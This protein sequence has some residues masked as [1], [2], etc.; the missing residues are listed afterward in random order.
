MARPKSTTVDAY[1]AHQPRGSRAVLQRVRGII[2]RVLPGAEETISYQIP[3][4]KVGGRGVVAFAGWKQHWSIYPV[5]DAI[6]ASPGPEANSYEFSKGTMRFPLT[7]RV[8]TTLVERVVRAVARR[9]EARQKTRAR[10][11][12]RPDGRRRRARG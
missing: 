3:T 5:T 10:P 9:A 12:T 6:R 4:Y 2:R 11:A 7:G 1:I 8:P